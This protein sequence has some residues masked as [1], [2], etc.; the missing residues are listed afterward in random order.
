VLI[1]AIF[2]FLD[3]GRDLPIL[4]QHLANADKARTTKRLI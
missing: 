4:R 3:F 2:Q 1:Q